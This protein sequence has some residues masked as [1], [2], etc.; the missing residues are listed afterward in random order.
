MTLPDTN[1]WRVATNHRARKI[2]AFRLMPV[3]QRNRQI[4]HSLMAYTRSVASLEPLNLIH[5]TQT[6]YIHRI[7]TV[8][9]R[10][11][12]T[13]QLCKQATVSPATTEHNNG[14][15]VF[16]EVCAPA[17]LPHPF[18]GR[19]GIYKRQTQFD[20]EETNVA[21]IIYRKK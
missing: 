9:C 7:C 6:Q 12:A 5:H 14:T 20:G 18:N 3:T 1:I 4:K 8:T 17:A 13:K 21:T 15:D 19:L 10:P 16:C 11:S 2:H